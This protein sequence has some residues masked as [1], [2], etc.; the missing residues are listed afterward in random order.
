MATAKAV[1]VTMMTSTARGVAMSKSP[2]RSRSR[3]EQE[4]RATWARSS[5]AKRVGGSGRAS[6]GTGRGRHEGGG[7]N[8]DNRSN[9]VGARRSAG[10]RRRLT[11]ER[12]GNGA[13][14]MQE[15]GDLTLV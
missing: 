1:E 5:L 3:P 4:I 10:W 15:R 13:A 8:A 2:G 7:S 11:Q 9:A 14:A 6:G 12:D